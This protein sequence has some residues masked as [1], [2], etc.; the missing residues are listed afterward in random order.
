M[1]FEPTR[2]AAAVPVLVEVTYGIRGVRVK[3]DLADDARAAIAA[4]LDHLTIVL[5][6][7]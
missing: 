6:L 3:A 1:A 4:Q 5:V 7:G 2:V